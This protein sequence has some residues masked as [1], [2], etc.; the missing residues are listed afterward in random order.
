M[1]IGLQATDLQENT[2]F[3][4]ITFSEKLLHKSAKFYSMFHHH[5]SVGFALSF[6]CFRPDNAAY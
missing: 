4:S 1:K 2:I 5:R 3:Q 6:L